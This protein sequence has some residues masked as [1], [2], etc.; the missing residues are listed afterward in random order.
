MN[1]RSTRPRFWLEVALAI[2]TAA[3]AIA[4]ILWPEWIEVVFGIE[5]DEGSGTLELGVTLTTAIA[6]GVLAMAARTDW[7]RAWG[8]A[9]S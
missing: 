4:T 9:R 8:Q 2:L 6:S 1:R 7:R 5:P 3:A